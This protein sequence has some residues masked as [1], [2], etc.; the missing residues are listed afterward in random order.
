MSYYD[1]YVKYK[2][3]YIELKNQIGGLP[4]YAFKNQ[5]TIFFK[6]VSEV[7]NQPRVIEIVDSSLKGTSQVYEGKITLYTNRSS[8]MMMTSV[9]YPGTPFPVTIKNLA[10]VQYPSEM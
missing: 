4:K 10:A 2:S 6:V 8:P 9:L 7:P 3:K 5:P 1:K